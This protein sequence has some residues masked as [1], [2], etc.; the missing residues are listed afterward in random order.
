MAKDSILPAPPSVEG[1]L[2]SPAPQAGEGA[3][4]RIAVIGAGLMGHGIAQVFAL[5]GHE[6]TLTD[7]DAPTLATA[8]ERI[9]VNLT[10]LGDDATAAG[11]GAHQCRPD[12]HRARRRLYRRSRARRPR[13][14]AQA[15]RRH[16]ARR[17]ARR[18][19]RQQ[20]LGDPDHRDHGEPR[21]PR[22]RARNPLVESA[23]PRAAGRG[24]RH[25]MDV[26]GN[27]R[28]LAGGAYTRDQPRRMAPL[29][30]ARSV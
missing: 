8:K 6:V 23:L 15:V 5:A 30:G 28:R 21:A 10:D 16:R 1:P 27:D 14:Q 17:A 3:K 12:R 13:R 19:P 7:A 26:A 20:H 9:R 4:A 25:R 24:D 29:P 18:D 11:A 22:T 2:P